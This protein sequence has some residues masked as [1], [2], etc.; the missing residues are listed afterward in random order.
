L[1]P[2]LPFEGSLMYRADLHRTRGA[3]RV[4]DEIVRQ[5]KALDAIEM[6][7]GVPRIGVRYRRT[8]GG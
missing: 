8:G 4:H 2:S 6:P 7:N 5:G 3:M 1:D